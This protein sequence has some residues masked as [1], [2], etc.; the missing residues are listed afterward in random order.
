MRITTK[1]LIAFMAM[2]CA[3]TINARQATSQRGFTDDDCKVAV[4]AEVVE[5]YQGDNCYINSLKYSITCTPD[6]AIAHGAIELSYDKGETWTT[7]TSDVFLNME[8]KLPIMHSFD[9]VKVRY[10]I[11]A[12]PQ[13]IYKD[14]WSASELTCE[15]EDYGLSPSTCPKFVA[16]KVV[17]NTGQGSGTNIN[18]THLGNTKEGYQIWGCQGIDKH[19]YTQW[20]INDG[21]K[22]S[23]RIGN[24]FYSNTNYVLTTDYSSALSRNVPEGPQHYH[25]IKAKGNASAEYFTWYGSETFHPYSWYLCP[26]FELKPTAEIFLDT[27]DQS[28]KQS[29]KYTMKYIDGKAVKDMVL[30]A[31][32]DNGET[33]YSVGGLNTGFNEGTKVFGNTETVSIPVQGNTVRYKI[34]ANGADG[35]KV[36]AKDWKWTYE[37]EDYPV[38][39]ANLDF[40]IT[41]TTP[42]LGTYAED[43]NTGARTVDTQVTWSVLDKMT[44][45]LDSIK[46]Q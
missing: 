28:L 23:Y 27:N 24:D 30:M 25:F 15:T 2:W 40:S 4:K 8:A 44:E 41:A 21:E 18:M 16:N 39:I 42:D 26:T 19:V 32:C 11:T 1:L 34:V 10:R 7:V 45:L 29:V 33:W 9:K 35:Y 14:T 5:Q 31:S 6:T 13:E 22:L 38:N 43:A 17:M 12:V 36:L 37:T 3:L 20:R 46:I